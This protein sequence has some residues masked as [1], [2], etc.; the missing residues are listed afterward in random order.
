MEGDGRGLASLVFADDLAEFTRRLVKVPSSP[1]PVYNVG[2]PPQMPRDLAAVVKKYI[3]GV[4]IS[5]GNKPMM[6]PEGETGLP[7][8]VSGQQ[9]RD[10]FGFGCMPLEEAVLIHINDARLEAGLEPIVV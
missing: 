3:P 7:W 2:G 1:N 4:E 6:D 10:D 8:L 5:F 9:A